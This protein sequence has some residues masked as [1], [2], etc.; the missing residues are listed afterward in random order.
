MKSY[1]EL[2]E[3][4]YNPAWASWKIK[5]LIGLLFVLKHLFSEVYFVLFTGFIWFLYYWIFFGISMETMNI[6]F[7]FLFGHFLFYI[8]Y[9]KEDYQKRIITDYLELKVLIVVAKDWYAERRA[10][11]KSSQKS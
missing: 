8:F 3:E 9:L 5:L 6:A 7:L 4:I 1:E 11:E 2:K 10:L